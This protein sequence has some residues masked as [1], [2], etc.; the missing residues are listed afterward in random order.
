MIPLIAAGAVSI[1]GNIVD[2]WKAHA[3]NVAATK[4]EQTASFQ[5]SLKAAATNAVSAAQQAAAAAQQQSAQA[6]PGTLQSVEQQ[7]LQSPDVQSLA[8]LSPNSTLSLQFNANGDLF[9]AQPGGGLRPVTIGQDVRQQLQQLNGTMRS[10]AAGAAGVVG[11]V[12]RFN[13]QIASSRQSVQ[14]S[15]A[16]V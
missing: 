3:Q 10:P 4:A 9:S 5:D 15:L 16:A 1:A 13:T 11:G 2:A 8:H 12:A 14:V 6:L 7:I